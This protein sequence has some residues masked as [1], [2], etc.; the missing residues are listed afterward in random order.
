MY[1]LCI[2][3]Q[4]PLE[5]GVG[6]LIS[7]GGLVSRLV[8]GVAVLISEGFAVLISEGGLVS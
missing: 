4:T 5:Q 7:E 1:T 3:G 8:R 2:V 6:A